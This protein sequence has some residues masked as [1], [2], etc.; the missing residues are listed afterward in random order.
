MSRR[1]H[2]DPCAPRARGRDRLR[3]Y[4]RAGRRRAPHERRDHVGRGIRRYCHRAHRKPLRRRRAVG[5]G[6]RLAALVAILVI[7]FNGTEPCGRVAPIRSPRCAAALATR[8]SCSATTRTRSTSGRGPDIRAGCSPGTLMEASASPRSSPA[9]AAAAEQALLAGRGRA[10]GRAP[11]L[12]QPRARPPA[13]RAVQRASRDHRL[14]A[15]CSGRRRQHAARVNARV[16]SR[17]LLG[18]LSGGLLMAACAGGGTRAPSRAPVTVAATDSVAWGIACSR[19]CVTSLPRSS[20]APR[21]TR[22]SPRGGCRFRRQLVR[23]GRSRPSLATHCG[24]DR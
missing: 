18:L 14:H 6:R 13:P 16:Q 9:A 8:R 17:L 24:H 15:P 10:R 3:Q 23:G 2:L 22:R 7:A 12:N 21:S 11:P 19:N 5:V 1:L 20:A 4:G